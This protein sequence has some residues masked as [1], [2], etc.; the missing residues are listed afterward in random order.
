MSA[1]SSLRD[2]V[3]S[4][5]SEGGSVVCGQVV[6]RSAS[7]RPAAASQLLHDVP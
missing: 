7:L 3:L 1:R 6:R 5:G 2:L 4:C